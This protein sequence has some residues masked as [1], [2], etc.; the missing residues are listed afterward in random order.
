[1]GKCNMRN[2]SKGSLYECGEQAE[3]K[4][5]RWPDGLFCVRHKNILENFFKGGWQKVI[6]EKG[7][8]ER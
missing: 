5:P 8:D 6:Y 1:M 7:Y 2:Y 3:W 4:H